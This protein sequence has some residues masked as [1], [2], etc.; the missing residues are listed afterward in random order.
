M[1][2]WI[3]QVLEGI[4]GLYTC[5]VLGPKE[6]QLVPPVTMRADAGLT[7]NIA[8]NRNDYFAT[9]GKIPG[10]LPCQSDMLKLALEMKGML[11]NL[12]SKHVQRIHVQGIVIN[13]ELSHLYGMLSLLYI[14]VRMPNLQNGS[15]LR[16]C[17]QTRS[18]G[19]VLFSKKQ[20][21]F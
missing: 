9:E 7:T 3:L 17:V 18:T 2:S 16:R 11:N 19:R 13:K 10:K 12:I 6:R 1:R 4:Y 15:T 21:G 5:L 20:E 8:R 14:G